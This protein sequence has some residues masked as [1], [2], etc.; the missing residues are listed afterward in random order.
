M[1]VVAGPVLDS[2]NAKSVE[3]LL[4]L[5]QLQWQEDAIRLDQQQWQRTGGSHRRPRIPSHKDA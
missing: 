2:M 3:V 1:E 5:Q 4:Q